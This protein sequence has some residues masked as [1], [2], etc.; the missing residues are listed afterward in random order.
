[1]N[2]IDVSQC[3]QLSVAEME[4]R[5]DAIGKTNVKFNP[6]R[7]VLKDCHDFMEHDLTPV[8]LCSPIT[9]AL[10]TTTSREMIEGKFH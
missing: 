10:L 5:N 8:V 2:K 9:G 7:D 4:D 1:M 6:I 3:V